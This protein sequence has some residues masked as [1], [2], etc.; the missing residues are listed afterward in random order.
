MENEDKNINNNSS[1]LISL[2]QELKSLLWFFEAI[3]KNPLL[4][5]DYKSQL[6]EIISHLN[7]EHEESEKVNEG[8]I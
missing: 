1:N 4:P 2:K 5:E 7:S 6:P 8:S 3:R